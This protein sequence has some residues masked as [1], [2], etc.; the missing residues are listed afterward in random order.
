MPAARDNYDCRPRSTDNDRM[1][2]M[3]F[4]SISGRMPLSRLRTS[5]DNRAKLDYAKKASPTLGRF[6]TVASAQALSSILEPSERVR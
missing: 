4:V 1:L 5:A 6:A 2:S 3:V